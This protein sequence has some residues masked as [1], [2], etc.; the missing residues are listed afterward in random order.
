MAESKVHLI[1]GC[2]RLPDA[3]GALVD[4]KPGLANPRGRLVEDL[5]KLEQHVAAEQDEHGERPRRDQSRDRT[6]GHVRSAS[7]VMG[8]NP[9]I[10]CLL[11]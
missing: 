6:T 10:F 11:P 7:A 9:A 3:R 1:H 2:A 8:R 5:P 4:G